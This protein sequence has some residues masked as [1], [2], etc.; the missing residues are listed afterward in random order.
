M[1]EAISRGR[2]FTTLEELEAQ[3]KGPV[4]VL[5]NTRDA[6]EG[7]VIVSIPKKNGNGADILRVPRTFLPIE[8][9]QQ[10][11][12]SQLLESAEFRKTI[13]QKLLK[14]V[15]SEYA[16][17]LLSTEEAK[18]ESE[19]IRNEDNKA[20]ALLKKA[21]VVEGENSSGV[22]EDDEEEYFEVA[23][24][25]EK[26]KGKRAAVSKSSAKE[27]TAATAKKSGP[28]MKVQSIVAAASRDEKTETQIIAQ[29]KNTRLKNA[30]LSYLSKQ[31]TDKPKIMKFLK[32]VLAEK[33]AAKA[34]A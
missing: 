2:K 25:T 31:Y 24:G 5:N 26:K 4:W 10:V 11:P 16:A 27:E 30:D 1:A 17:V 19:R 12:R 32:A 9:T 28:S 29:L 22:G 23:N 6:L 20:R 14:L 18:D 33:R 34:A 7:K 13:G 21:G 15:T 8:L 3:E